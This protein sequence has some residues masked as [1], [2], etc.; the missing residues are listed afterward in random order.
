M[1]VVAIAALVALVLV[2]WLM[3]GLLRSEQRAHARREDLLVNQLL[4]AAGHPWQPSP[5]DEQRAQTN[6]HKRIRFFPAPEQMP[7]N[8]GDR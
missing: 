2:V 1:T 5:A 6:G 8:G 4:A 3:V 7:V